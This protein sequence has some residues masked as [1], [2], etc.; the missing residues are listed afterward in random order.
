HMAGELPASSQP[1]PVFKVL[2]R[3]TNRIQQKGG[4]KEEVLHPVSTASGVEGLDDAAALRSAVHRKDVA[5]AESRLAAIA[6]SSA[7][8]AL[9]D[10]LYTVQEHTEVHRVVLPYRSWDLL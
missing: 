6:Q 4:R 2:Y 10:L 1:L 8:D 7:S 3:N 5:A 9:N